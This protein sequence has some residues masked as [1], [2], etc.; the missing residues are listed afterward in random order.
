MHG[1]SRCSDFCFKMVLALMRTPGLS[2]ISQQVPLMRSPET[3]TLVLSLSY[4]PTIT[5]QVNQSVSYLI[6]IAV[7]FCLP[8]L[9]SRVIMGIKLN[10]VIIDKNVLWEASSFLYWMGVQGSFL[11]SG[12]GR[13]VLTH[14]GTGTKKPKFWAWNKVQEQEWWSW[15]SVWGV[16]MWPRAGR[17]RKSPLPDRENLGS[18]LIKR[19]VDIL[20]SGEVVLACKWVNLN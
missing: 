9:D 18:H 10:N 8:H 20:R 17:R 5:Q 4:T 12:Q 3:W 14:L 15:H 13:A 1:K 6:H 7:W 19:N 2:A 16:R 11:F